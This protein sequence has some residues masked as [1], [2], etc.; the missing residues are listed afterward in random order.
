MKPVR[1]AILGAG[2]ALAVR[3]LAYVLRVDTS[4]NRPAALAVGVLLTGIA[5]GL[6]ALKWKP[7]P[8]V[9]WI[10]VVAW[11]MAAYVCLTAWP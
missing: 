2:A 4:L 1:G 5:A 8:T 9:Y 6:I 10:F 11:S 7:L 3:L